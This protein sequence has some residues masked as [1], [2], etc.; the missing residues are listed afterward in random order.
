MLN[1][2]LY[3][4]KRLRN[5]LNDKNIQKVAESIYMSKLMY[6]L[7]LMGKIR[8][9]NSDP[10]QNHFKELQ[11]T[12][13]KLLRFLNKSQIADKIPTTTILSKLNMCS[14]NQL[15][16]KIKLTEMWKA[17]NVPNH[18]LNVKTAN[19]HEDLRSSRSITNGKLIEGFS[20]LATNTFLND[21]TRALNKAP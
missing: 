20:N 7:Q 19:K 17:T 9:K 6:G 8:W 3:L 14:V 10:T 18:N 21:A 11:K 1:K 4:I 15:N 12:Q 2:R 13:N 5:H 16:A